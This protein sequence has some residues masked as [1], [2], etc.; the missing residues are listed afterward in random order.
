[1]TAPQRSNIREIVPKS[2]SDKIHLLDQ[3]NGQ[4]L[5]ARGIELA[6][7]GIASIQNFDASDIGALIDVH[8]ERLQVIR[9]QAARAIGAD[10]ASSAGRLS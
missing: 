1:M 3:I 8:I 10:R 6:V 2:A 5:F 4:I 9:D 7:V